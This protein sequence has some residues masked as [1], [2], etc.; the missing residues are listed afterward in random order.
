MRGGAVLTAPQRR[1]STKMGEEPHSGPGDTCV[2]CPHRTT[3]RFRPAVC[4]P[5]KP[6]MF[7]KCL[8]C[9]V[10]QNARCARFTE[11][12]LRSAGTITPV[13]FHSPD[14]K[15]TVLFFKKKKQKTFNPGFHYH[16]LACVGSFTLLLFLQSPHLSIPTG[17]DADAGPRRTCSLHTGSHE[18]DL[19]KNYDNSSVN[20]KASK[21]VPFFN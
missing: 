11:L 13:S 3:V 14:F 1:E 19:G 4:F 12:K 15:E 6:L 18:D 21:P 16:Q 20:C 5:R 10:F 8:K 9:P 17:A 7:K 2:A